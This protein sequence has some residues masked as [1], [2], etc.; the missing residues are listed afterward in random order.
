MEIVK[1]N[2]KTYNKLNQHYVN[3]AKN[4]VMVTVR[5]E[6]IHIHVTFATQTAKVPVAVRHTPDC[7]VS[8]LAVALHN[9]QV[10]AAEL[11]A[12][13]VG[14]VASVKAAVRAAG[15]NIWFS[16]VYL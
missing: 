9:V 11:E 16:A 5:N 13:T 4:T 10:L 3:F 8:C 2:K 1:K 6:Q 15:H 14:R 7:G 12:G